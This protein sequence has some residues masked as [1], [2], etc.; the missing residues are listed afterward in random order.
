MILEVFFNYF[1]KLIE[2]EASLD[3][4]EPNILEMYKRVALETAT[5]VL[6]EQKFGKYKD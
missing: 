1:F 3:C 4:T 5:K 6:N 2:D